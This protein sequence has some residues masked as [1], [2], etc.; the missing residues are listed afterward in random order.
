[1]N[2]LHQLNNIE[3]GKL[4]A[5]L[6]PDELASILGA[7]TKMRN[8]MIDNKEEIVSNW[9]NGFFSVELWYRLA[10]ELSI[11]VRTQRK[12][13]LTARKFAGR[14][15]QGY[16]ALFTIHCIITYANKEKRKLDFGM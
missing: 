6:F 10:E 15:F 2:A 14:L 8:M 16:R 11:E 7:I 3:K 1:M 13:L 9:N 5:D 4:L 12:S